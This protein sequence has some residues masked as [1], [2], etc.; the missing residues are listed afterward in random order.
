MVK[1]LSARGFGN[2]SDADITAWP[3]TI[4]KEKDTYPDAQ[5]VVP[6]HGN[7]GSLDLLDYTYQLLTDR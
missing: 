6:S 1:A 2:T 3:N 7:F 4:A 5:Y